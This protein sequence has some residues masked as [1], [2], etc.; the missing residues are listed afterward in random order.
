MPL[1]YLAP[2][3]IGALPQFVDVHLV[4]VHIRIPRNGPQTVT[5]LYEAVDANGQVMDSRPITVTLAQIAAE[6]PAVFNAVKGDVRADG[7]ERA[8]KIYPVGVVI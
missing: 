3:T 1:H 7:Y 8:Q 2:K 6:K 5:Y 4:D